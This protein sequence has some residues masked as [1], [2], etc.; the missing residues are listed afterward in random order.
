MND[1]MCNTPI[2]SSCTRSVAGGIGFPPVVAEQVSSSMHTHGGGYASCE[3]CGST[4]LKAVSITSFQRGILR[5][6]LTTS[7]GV[8]YFGSFMRRARS[9]RSHLKFKSSLSGGSLRQGRRRR[10]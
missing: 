3:F 2:C 5:G 6:A 8:S 1:L 10:F 9:L 4:T 7:P